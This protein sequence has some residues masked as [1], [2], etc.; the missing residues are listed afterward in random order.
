[1]FMKLWAGQS[2]PEPRSTSKSPSRPLKN[3]G[4]VAVHTQQSQTAQSPISA[5]L[6]V[7]QAHVNGSLLSSRGIKCPAP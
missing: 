6:F 5:A 3:E 2:Q 4:G 1:M 7:L